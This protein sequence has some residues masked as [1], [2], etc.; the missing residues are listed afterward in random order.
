MLILPGNCNI[1]VFGCGYTHDALVI[2]WLKPAILCVMLIVS[3]LH[4]GDEDGIGL[5]DNHQCKI[6]GQHCVCC[7]LQNDQHWC[8]WPF[9]SVGE[10]IAERETFCSYVERMGMFFTANNIV[11]TTGEGST[12]ANR[13]VAERKRTIFLTEV[14]AEIYSTLSNL[15]APVKPK[16]TPFTEIVSALEKHYNPK[17]LEIAQSFH[18]GSRNQKLGESIGDYVLAL[19]KLAIHYCNYGEF[20]DRALRDRLVCG[21]SNPKIQNKLL[22][23]EDLTFEKA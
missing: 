2:K 22:N 5:A 7:S 18:F 14:G 12:Q 6:S 11:D 21:L 1:L 20:L 3:L 8:K 9:G 15:L 13:V 10:F 4:F 19:K 17:P 16:D 23:T